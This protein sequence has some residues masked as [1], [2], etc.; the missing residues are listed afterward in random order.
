LCAYVYK[1]CSYVYKLCA[2][3][4]KFHVTAH[5]NFSTTVDNYI[6][7]LFPFITGINLFTQRNG[8]TGVINSF[9]DLL[10]IPHPTY[11]TLT[12]WAQSLCSALFHTITTAHFQRFRHWNLN[13][14]KKIIL[15]SRSTSVRR[16]IGISLNC[17]WRP[18]YMNYLLLTPTCN[19]KCVFHES[20]VRHSL[21]QSVHF[22]NPIYLQ[23][24]TNV[25][26]SRVLSS[27]ITNNRSV[28]ITVQAS[29]V[30]LRFFEVTSETSA[31]IFVTW[32]FP[33]YCI[34]G[35]SIHAIF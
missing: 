27:I 32:L 34:T 15:E 22:G 1:L 14:I 20:R 23:N 13:W 2:Y 19:P 5:L 21:L 31:I 7:Q 16:I 35:D 10:F 24:T 4:Y 33:R 29:R 3:I 30:S 11:T 18:G 9:R 8:F 25:C 17:Q 28:P 26:M 12:L 6:A